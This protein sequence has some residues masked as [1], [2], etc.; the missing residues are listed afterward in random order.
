MSLNM[1]SCNKLT[2]LPCMYWRYCRVRCRA[3]ELLRLVEGFFAPAGF[4]EFAAA[5]T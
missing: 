1:F 5:D 2:W 4:A 3:L